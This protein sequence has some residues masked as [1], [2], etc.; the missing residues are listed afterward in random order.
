MEQPPDAP[1]FPSLQATPTSLVSLLHWR[2]HDLE[3]WAAATDHWQPA[4][5][6]SGGDDCAFKVWDTR[7]GVGAPAWVNRR[8]HGAGVCCVASG[9]WQEHLVA[10]GSYDEKARL[11]DLR[12]ASQPL[13]IA[14]VC[15]CDYTR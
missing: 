6:F 8:A 15:V 1:H 11:W 5:I 2:A 13:H 9:P 14:E 4:L 3:A 7:Q 10:T 12:N